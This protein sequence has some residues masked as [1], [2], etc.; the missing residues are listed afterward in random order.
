MLLLLIVM[1]PIM[2]WLSVLGIDYSYESLVWIVLWLLLDLVWFIYFVC[3]HYRKWQTPWKM[4]VWVK[5]V[6]VK[7][8]K[9]TFLQ[10]L[11]RAFSVWVPAIAAWAIILLVDALWWPLWIVSAVLWILLIILYALWY[12]WA[13]WDEKKRTFHDILAK[14]YVIEDNAI[15]KKWVITW[16]ILIFVLF[17]LITT[18]IIVW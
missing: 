6:D 5:V 15:S 8:A 17:L 18:L 12:M 3:F 13:W 14:T 2:L 4:L 16:N 11:W 1:V 7:K 10:S 9:I